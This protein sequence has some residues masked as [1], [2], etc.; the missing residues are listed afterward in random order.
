M[1]LFGGIPIIAGTASIWNRTV[2]FV[3]MQG[4]QLWGIKCEL[5]RMP[6]P[7]RGMHTQQ[8]HEKRSAITKMQQAF[9]PECSRHYSQNAF[10][11]S[12]AIMAWEL[13]PHQIILMSLI[14]ISF[15]RSLEFSLNPLY[16]ARL[17]ISSDRIVFPVVVAASPGQKYCT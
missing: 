10:C 13:S 6:K 15:R 1:E 3:S 9:F 5:S 17:P 11:L 8:F 12:D 4:W 16:F 7:F 2:A 14:G